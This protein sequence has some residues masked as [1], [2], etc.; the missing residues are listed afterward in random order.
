MVH[1]I[2][3][4][5]VLSRHYTDNAFVSVTL[6]PHSAPILTLKFPQHNT[7]REMLL[8]LPQYNSIIFTNQTPSLIIPNFA[9]TWHSFPDS[10]LYLNPCITKTR[11]CPVPSKHY[12]KLRLIYNILYERVPNSIKSHP[13]AYIHFTSQFYR[14]NLH[15]YPLAFIIFSSNS[16][17]TFTN[18]IRS[19]PHRQE[20]FCLCVG[21]DCAV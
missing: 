4:T 15:T 12:N 17:H 10:F 19:P 20:F 3:S 13:I 21:F 8:F 5:R 6:I 2:S 16:R 11:S 18:I 1:F 9:A 14:P 7:T